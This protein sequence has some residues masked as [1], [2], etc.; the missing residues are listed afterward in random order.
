MNSDQGLE[1]IAL[2][3]GQLIEITEQKYGRHHEIAVRRWALSA[4][5]FRPIKGDKNIGAEDDFEKG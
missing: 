4:N 5:H 1:I 3:T 2:S